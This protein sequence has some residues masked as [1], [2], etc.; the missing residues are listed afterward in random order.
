MAPF[1]D[2]PQHDASS[3]GFNA[4]T[5][6]TVRD[7]SL[8]LRQLMTCV[9]IGKAL[10]STF[11]MEEI[12]RIVLERLCELIPAKNWTLF[13]LDPKTKDLKFELV[14][15]VEKEALSHLRVKLGE[16]IAG[17]VAAT[18]EPILVEDVAKDPRFSPKVDL[19]TGFV[20]RSIICLPLKIQG[21]VI[22][23]VEVIN[24]EDP[25]LFHRHSMMALSILADYLAIAIGNAIN[26]RKM[27]DLALTDTVTGFYNTR[28]LHQ[29]L[30]WLLEPLSPKVGE[31]SLVF[32]DMDDFKQVVDAHGH[33]M[34]TKVLK[35]VAGVIACHLEE[36]DRL[37]HYGG[38]EF[39]ILLPEQGK[40]Q[41]LEKVKAI[42]KALTEA[43]FLQQEGRGVKVTASFGMASYPQDATDKAELLRLADRSMFRSKES[44]KDTITI[45]SMQ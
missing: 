14:A 17:T 31:I 6:D 32:L 33:L 24:P 11:N 15:G 34:G 30:E 29:Y 7:N 38:D 45:V 4:E 41:A 19:V 9:E 16:G 18:G 28:F 5:D 22:G 44:G 37:V 13:L 39:V 25:T 23:V 42:R 43:V 2:S 35:E 12:L 27:A 36:A 10:T 1:P 26:Y 40:A 3:P 20:T 8:Y 21:S